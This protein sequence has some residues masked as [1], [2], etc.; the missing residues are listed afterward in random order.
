[1]YL[2]KPYIKC[3]FFIHQ[4]YGFKTHK[5]LKMH[6]SETTFVG[7]I[8][9]STHN[10]MINGSE[11]IFCSVY[12]NNAVQLRIFGHYIDCKFCIATCKRKYS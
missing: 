7:A 8:Q 9:Q 10:S 4:I 1:M 6:I 11:H 5:R 3:S 12:T 2:V